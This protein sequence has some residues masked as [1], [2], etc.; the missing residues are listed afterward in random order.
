VIARENVQDVYTL[1]PMQEGLLFHALLDPASPA[2]VEQFS[3]RL[4]GALDV[5]AFET[6]WQ[7]VV[8]RHDVLRT[9]FSADRTKRPLQIVLRERPL[10]FAVEDL[11]GQPEAARTAR[12]AACREGERARGFDLA[13]DG[14]ARVRVLRLGE[15]SWEVVWTFHHIL[16]DGW[17]VGVLH[18]ELMQIYRDLRAGRRPALPPPSPFARYIAWLEKRDPSASLAY[19]ASYLAG[20][21]QLATVPAPARADRQAPYALRVRTVP[22]PPA[23]IARLRAVAAALGA[24]V[25]VLFHAAWGLVL[26]RYN[27]T[28]DVVFGSI[29][30]GRPAELPGIDRAVG[31]Y[32]NVV[33]VRVRVRPGLRV[34]DLVA[35]LMRDA[36]EAAPHHHCTLSDIRQRTPLRERLLDHVLAF[37]NFPVAAAPGGE[38]AITVEAVTRVEQ[39]SYDVLVVVNPAGAF[40]LE[41]HYNERVFDAAAIARTGGHLARAL[42]AIADDPDQAIGAI[43]I[44][45]PDERDQLVHGFNG[46]PHEDSGPATVPDVFERHVAA[47]PGAPAVAAADVTLDHAEL[48]A[49]A[50]RLAHRLIALG[51]GPERVVATALERSPELVVSQLAALKAGAAFL[52]L[53]LDYPAGRLA[54]MLNDARPVAVLT[55]TRLATRLPAGAPSLCLDDPVEHERLAALPAIAPTDATRRAPLC[56]DQTAYVIYTSGSTGTPKGVMVTHRNLLSLCLGRECRDLGAAGPYLALAPVAFDASTLEIF[57]PLLNGSTVAIL[58]PGVPTPDAVAAAI[59]RHHVA[60]LLLSPAL[61]HAVVEQSPAILAGVAHV[62]AGGDVVPGATVRALLAAKPA[63]RVVNA[64]GPTEGAIVTSLHPMTQVSDVPDLVPIGSPVTNRRVYVLDERL[65]P[66]PI[67]VAGELCI[68]GP[69][70][71]RGYLNRPALTAERFVADPFAAE[72]GARMYRTGDR[73]RWRADGALEF[74]GR[75]DHQVKVRGFRIELGEIEAALVAHPSIGQAAVLAHET[76]SNAPGERRLVA[77]VVPAADTTVPLPAVLRAHLLDRLP[78]YMVPAAFVTLAGL[79]L[80]PNGKLDRAAL[81]APVA[82]HAPGGRRPPRTPG[83]QTLAALWCDVLGV[84]EVGLDDDFFE[85]GG[86][87]LTA[88]RVIARIRKAFD[89]DLPLAALFETPRLADLAARIADGPAAPSAPAIVRQPRTARE[90]SC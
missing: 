79:P 12:V 3:Y 26:G 31:L 50:N 75:I 54:F 4:A 42:A 86:H 43:D 68:G 35:A 13:R 45:D 7:E 32:I 87:S 9:A 49:R 44:L 72:A 38:D 90:R 58:P 36:A 74:L 33:P 59:T 48:D 47:T 25:S 51:A 78:E 84:P 20:Y 52:P 81:P 18:D 29:V 10:D 77:Y 41:L 27:G 16:L 83:E 15:Q 53:D 69:G 82:G 85:L 56:A 1:S 6:A 5:A 11:R 30:S 39:T 40:A 62:L 61:L 34:R 66:V 80:T 89:R 64:Y 60:V 22:L 17:S 65:S 70:V 57:T 71:A 14:L 28:G 63:G 23:T 2:Y 73:V 24:T 21:E 76:G 8:R 37:E 88:T 19:W 46:A 55:T 67:G